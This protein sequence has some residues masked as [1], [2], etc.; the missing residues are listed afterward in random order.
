MTENLRLNRSHDKEKNPLVTGPSDWA[1]HLL[2]HPEEMTQDFV[3]S[4]K[5]LANQPFAGV[6][7]YGA[8]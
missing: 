5:T 6:H 7:P 8:T 4:D 3:S 1:V 2:I